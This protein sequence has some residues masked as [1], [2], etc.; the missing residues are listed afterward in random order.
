[1]FEHTDESIQESYLSGLKKES[2]A[3]VTTDVAELR[4]EVGGAEQ[5]QAG[6]LE[7]LLKN[8]RAGVQAIGLLGVPMLLCLWI[9]L[10]ER[11]PRAD[12]TFLGL[13]F[14]IVG[15]SVFSIGIELG[16]SKLGDQIG[17]KIPAAYKTVQLQ[18][19]KTV[20]K[21]FDQAVV[22]TAITVEGK[23]DS[24]FV[25]HVDEKYEIIPYQGQAFN[26]DRETFEYLP[27]WPSLWG[28]RWP[29]WNPR[30]FNLCVHSWIRSNVG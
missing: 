27:Y 21:N 6:M 30:C 13:A 10:R 18:D 2:R 15:M 8:F 24:F 22:K 14:A 1:V 11:L 29:W 16:L 12:E 3:K 17:G 19:Q 7:I 4:R 28:R 9:L 5:S 20:L 26:S 25:A 23:K